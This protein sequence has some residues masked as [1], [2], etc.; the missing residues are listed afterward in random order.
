MGVRYSEVFRCADGHLWHRFSVVTYWSAS[1]YHSILGLGFFT[2]YYYHILHIS[3]PM[4]NIDCML[5]VVHPI[6]V[7]TVPALQ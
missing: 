2:T 7:E 6:C 5:Y 1:T 3:M 4:L